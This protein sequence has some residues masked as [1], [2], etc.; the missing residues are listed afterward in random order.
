MATLDHN[1]R[2]PFEPVE[3]IDS[4]R[5]QSSNQ[6][7]T[8]LSLLLFLNLQETFHTVG[9]ITFL[10]KGGYTFSIEVWD[11]LPKNTTSISEVGHE[12]SI[13]DGKW[14]VLGAQ[15]IPDAHFQ[16]DDDDCFIYFDEK[17][18]YDWG[19]A[20]SGSFN[21]NLKSVTGASSIIVTKNMPRF[22]RGNWLWS[23]PLRKLVI[24]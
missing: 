9:E 20:W 21:S 19:V 3:A 23:C 18:Q 10:A 2:A 24:A 6:L 7:E 15:P 8:I 13:E 16:F 4:S 5:K 22:F 14:F 12:C 11:Q 17:C 1:S